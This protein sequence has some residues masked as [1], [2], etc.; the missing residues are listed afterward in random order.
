MNVLSFDEVANHFLTSKAIFWVGSAVSLRIAPT[1]TEYYSLLLDE[2]DA[3]GDELEH[4]FSKMIR[5]GCYKSHF[6]ELKFELLNSRLINRHPFNDSV[7]EPAR[8]L[9]ELFKSLFRIERFNHNHLCLAHLLK[10]NQ[11]Y[12]IITTNFDTCIEN[13]C[14][15]INFLPIVITLQNLKDILVNDMGSLKGHI[16][17]IHGCASEDTLIACLEDIAKNTFNPVLNS[18]FEKLYKEQFKIFSFGYSGYGD[19]DLSPY[20]FGFKENLLI[21]TN[22]PD[23]YKGKIN[24][25]C[26]INLLST[27]PEKNALV[28]LA[29]IDSEMCVPNS[30][31]FA[32]SSKGFFPPKN[33]VNAFLFQTNLHQWLRCKITGDFDG[34]SPLDIADYR[35][36]KKFS[37]TS[38]GLE[39]FDNIKIYKQNKGLILFGYSK[40]RPFEL[41]HAEKNFV[42]YFRESITESP[43]YFL[44]VTH[45]TCR[46]AALKGKLSYDLYAESHWR[47][48]ESESLKRILGK[49]RE[50]SNIMGNF[51]YLFEFAIVSNN[52]ILLSSLSRLVTEDNQL[53]KQEI[54][55][56]KS[57]NQKNLLRVAHQYYYSMGD[58]W[59]GMIA[60]EVAFRIGWHDLLKEFVNA[61]KVWSIANIH[62]KI[63][64]KLAYHLKKRRNLVQRLSVFLFNFNTISWLNL[65]TMKLSL[66][67]LFIRFCVHKKL[68]HKKTPN[69][70][71]KIRKK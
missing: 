8:I 39:Y 55:F 43:N 31:G 5:S 1:P 14:R 61:Q 71:R 15:S 58:R 41:I 30:P 47:T 23:Q 33:I 11:I 22:T 7:D 69:F 36:F 57:S 6:D 53:S 51:M 32:L 68:Y 2:V 35:E 60:A 63:I 48:I 40:T 50:Y 59:V 27:L 21:F 18:F 34:F 70:G 3:N 65:I 20:F 37:P 10:N 56:S 42:D 38:E 4:F 17:K 62:K 26:I 19:V 25:I 66:Y 64:F 46:I 49:F 28:L 13:A 16:I 52:L 67:I 44:S 29:G 45:A 54:N 12:F 9:N 24:N